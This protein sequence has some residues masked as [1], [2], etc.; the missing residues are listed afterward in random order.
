MFVFGF[1]F[2]LGL[3]FGFG[4]LDRLAAL[5]AVRARDRVEVLALLHGVTGRVAL[6]RALEEALA[7]GRADARG[8]GVALLEGRE[9]ERYRRL[10]PADLVRVRIR[11][12]VLGLGLVLTP[13]LTKRLQA[14]DLE[15]LAV[16]LEREGE[17]GRAEGGVPHVDA[18]HVLGARPEHRA[19][20]LHVRQ[21]VR[22]TLGLG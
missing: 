15:L 13:P 4:Q 22:V 11:V 12:R 8:R 5:R 21:L 10:Q 18:A 20:G 1:G 6:L 2:G 9:L 7:T 17:G 14:A 3:G 19:D 16:G